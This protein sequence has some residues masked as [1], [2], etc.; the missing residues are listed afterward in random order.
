MPDI[1]FG[2]SLPSLNEKEAVDEVVESHGPVTIEVSERL[3]YGGKQRQ[4]ERRHLLLP[5]LHALQ[6]ASGW[7]SPGGL[8]YACRILEVPPAEAYGVA[9]F[10]HLFSDQPP[11]GDQT[12]HVCNDIACGLNEA[13]DLIDGLKKEGYE[14]KSSPCLGQCERG[15]AVFVQRV[16]SDDSVLFDTDPKEFQKSLTKSSEKELIKLPQAGSDHLRLLSRIGIVDP[17]SLEEYRSLGGYEALVKALEIGDEQIIEEVTKSGLRGRGGAAFPTGIKWKAVAEE[18]RRVHHLVCNADE[19]EPGTF[20]D[21]ILM[22]NDPFALIESMTIAALAV[23]AEKGW[24]YIRGEYP[25]AKQRLIQAIEKAEKSGLLGEDILGSGRKFDIELRSGAG[26]YICGEETALFN[27]IEGFRGEPR[28]K[29]PFP[30]TNGLFNE[31]TVVNNVETLANIPRIILNGGEA[32]ASEGTDQSSGTRLFCLSGRVALPG[33]YEFEFG[34]TLAEVLDAAG[35]FSG[36]GNLKTILLGGAAG[37]FVTPESINLP[38][39]FEDTRNAGVSLGS[40]VIMPFSDEDDLTKTVLRIAEFFRDESCGQCVPCR[41]GTVRQEELLIRAAD[42]QSFNT[43]ISLFDD[44]A[45][46]MSDASICGLGH[47]AA[48]AV[49]SALNLGLMETK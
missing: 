49:R 7:I 20:K 22:E 47:T 6:R 25:L 13:D 18:K 33:L 32:Y 8:D 46:V 5:A 27:S 19:S 4:K 11:N 37:S 44:L 1:K 45:T 28:N 12:L 42:K 26:A 17:N 31:P 21:R 10:Y 36:S 40:G 34:A 16:A 35:G 23:G 24:F 2:T 29:P 43:D 9:T 41:V 48:S 15:S 3:V 39:T 14:T 38:L 30:T